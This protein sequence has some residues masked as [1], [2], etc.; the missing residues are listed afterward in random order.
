MSTPKVAFFH[1][2][3]TLGPQINLGA[4]DYWRLALPAAYLYDRGWDV[5]FARCIAQSK[6]G[7]FQVQEPSG[8]WLD[9]REIIILQNWMGEGTAKAIRKARRAGQV[10]I[11]DLDDDYW[12]FPENHIAVAGTDPKLRPQFNRDHYRAAIE[13]SSLVTVSTP[14][15]AETLASWRP[16]VHLIR[17]YIDLE[18]WSPSP[19]G[20]HI[21]WV[22]MTAF[23]GRDLELLKD[24]VVPWLRERG[25]FFY[26]GGDSTDAPS[27][28]EILDYDRVSARKALPVALYQKLWE[29]LRVALVPID[30]T[31]FG[32]SKSWIKG[33]ESCARGIPFIA[34]DHAEYRELGVGLL[35]TNPGDW[36]KHLEALEDP[37][38]YSEEAERN[39]AAVEQ[40][41][42]AKNGDRW[43]ELL[44]SL[45]GTEPKRKAPVVGRMTVEGTK[46][47]LMTIQLDPEVERKLTELPT[48]TTLAERQL[49][50]HFAAQVWDGKHDIFEN[51][52]LLGGATRALGI[53]MYNN[54]NRDPEALLQTFDWF[55]LNQPDPLDLPEDAFLQLVLAGKLTMDEVNAAHDQGSFL[56][57]FRTLHSTEDYTSVLR[58]HVGYLP[59]FPGDQAPDGAQLYYLPE[60]REFSLLFIDGCKS[61]YGTKYWAKETFPY[62][63]V[64][65][66]LIFQDFGQFTCFW[67]SALVGLLGKRLRLKGFVDHTYAF[68]VVDSLV[69][70]AEEMPDDPEGFACSDFDRIYDQLVKEAEGR[71]DRFAIASLTCHRAAARAW[72]GYKDEARALIDGLLGRAEF[73]GIRPYLLAARQAPTYH[74]DGTRVL[75]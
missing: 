67:I 74:A 25:K 47:R 33:L 34:S 75:L 2:H 64:G 3:W 37:E 35:V 36:V 19:P 7:I 41:S 51:G 31:A 8:D 40:F 12:Q 43:A 18:A 14:P 13:A 24:T 9:D 6:E 59:G 16:P 58:P 5:V 50:L 11:Q 28:Q 23:R 62:V 73:V 53:G 42:I 63:P 22:G 32:R 72:L 56:S 57:L 17:N 20:D 15:L 66:H 65:S 71:G 69:G 55:S 30:D 61:W 4:S 21:G 26:H 10:V 68:E 39:K 45:V 27:A 44:E 48:A 38:F 52:P 29:P 54:E 70:V 49:A 46:K 60:E 1:S